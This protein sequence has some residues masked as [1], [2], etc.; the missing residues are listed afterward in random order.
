M[1]IIIITCVL[2]WR[3]N[4]G[5]AQ[6]QFNMIDHL[7]KKHNITIIFPEDSQNKMVYAKELQQIWPDV[8]LRPYRIWK[9]MLYPRFL[10][11]KAERALKLAFTPES[12]R[13]K[14]QRALKHYGIYPS[15]GFMHFVN[16]II[17]EEHADIVQVEFY[18]CLWLIRGLPDNVRKI[19]IHHELRYIKNE[20]TI[21]AYHPTEKELKW[22]YELKQEELDD[23]NRYDTVVTLTQQDKDYLQRDGVCKPIYVS[24]AAINTEISPFCPWNHRLAFVGSF[25]HQ[26]N[27]EGIDW[28]MNE[29][30]PL[31][32]KAPLLEIIGKGWPTKYKTKD[33]NT[34]GFVDDLHEVTSGSIMIVPILSGSGMRMKILEAAAMSMPIITTTVGVEGLNFK[35]GDSC[36]IADS[37]HEFASAIKQLSENEDI[38][39]KLGEQAN[40][41]FREN[42]S[43]D[44]LAEV[45]NKVYSL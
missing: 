42:Y 7:R 12:E 6:A 24:P 8:K 16:N 21:M 4:S 41:V 10:K 35:H 30:L 3:L 33:I 25:L 9:Q 34:L 14:V 13:F 1:N 43:K 17:K 23:L 15:N 44:I 38:C 29:V 22:M 28:Y 31:L 37:P 45:R 5:G 27:V 11:D 32:Q 26:P 39:R 2:P 36:I 20:R 19:F 40:K 18:P